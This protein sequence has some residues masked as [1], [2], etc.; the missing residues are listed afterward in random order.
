MTVL[1]DTSILLLAMHPDAAP[2][3]D[4]AT[5]QAVEHAKQRVDYLIRKL[6]NARKKVVIPAPV[7]S[8]ILVHAGKSTNEYVQNF[9]QSPFR[10]VPFDTRAA[11]EC[12]DAI[13][14][15][16]IKGKGKENPRAKIKFDRQ[17]I[18]IAQV[19]RVGAIYSDDGDIFKYGA[20]AGIKVIR[21]YEL[22][23]DPEDRQHQLNL[24]PAESD[25]EPP[26]V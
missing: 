12:A 16:G 4:P 13:H 8:E 23:V 2:P 10:I 26:T 7:L 22:E 9:Q 11:I 24:E 6:S 17:I 14:R 15:H 3:I 5:K 25:E 1:F 19:E 20:Q 18:A 21:S